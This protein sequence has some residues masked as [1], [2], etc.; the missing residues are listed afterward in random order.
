MYRLILL[1]QHRYRETDLED[2]AATPVPCPLI[3]RARNTGRA[4]TDATRASGTSRSVPLVVSPPRLILA[5]LQPRYGIFPRSSRP[6][7]VMSKKMEWVKK[8]AK[9]NSK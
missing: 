3:T 7:P 6:A 4:A 2:Q 5:S 9:R 1:P 8:R